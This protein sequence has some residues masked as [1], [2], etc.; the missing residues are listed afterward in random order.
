MMIYQLRCDI[1]KDVCEQDVARTWLSVSVCKAT[2]DGGAW[3][4]D[5]CPRCAEI[6]PLIKLRPP[7]DA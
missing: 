5:I 7:T 4:T 2:R 3:G 6:T 1:C